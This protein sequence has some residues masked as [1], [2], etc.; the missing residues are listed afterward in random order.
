MSDTNK[1][2]PALLRLA[3]VLGVTP[4]SLTTSE[5]VATT[6]AQLAKRI[7]AVLDRLAEKR[8]IRLRYGLGDGYVYTLEE[9]G[10]AFKVS[11]ELVSKAKK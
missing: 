2:S 11:R 3:E 4:E 5:R 7:E 6:Q 10:G 1:F 8:S 9:I